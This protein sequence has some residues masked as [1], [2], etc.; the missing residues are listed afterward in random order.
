[1][2]IIN[3]LN[4]PGLA[5][6][7]AI[8]GYTI[9]EIASLQVIDSVLYELEHDATGAKHVHI[10]NNDAENTFSVA[11]KTVPHDSTGV[12]HILEHTALCGS[13]LFPVRDPF[14]SMLKRSLSTFMNAFTASD[15][16]MYPFTTQNHKD[17]YNLADVYLDSAFYPNIDELSFKQEGY[18][19]EIE[20]MTAEPDHSRLV[21]KGV[22]YNEMKGAMSSPDQVMA[23][24]M[25]NALYPDV[26]YCHNSGGEP[27]VIPSL[28]HAELV[29]FHRRHYHPSN[30]FFYTYGNL[31]LKEHL[32]FI[33]TKI[34]SHFDLIDPQTDVPPQPRWLKPRTAFYPYPLGPNEN[35]EKKYQVCIAWL[36]AD[37][38]DSFEVLVL[39]LLEQILL[40]NS[41]SP[42][43]RALIE[44]G[45]G[46]ALSDGSGFDPDN[47][48]TLFACGLKDVK[49]TDAPA[50]E[51]IIFDVFN[52]LIDN[53]IEAER[54]ESAI[55]QIE[56]HRK[57]VTNTPYPYGIKLLLTFAGSWFHGGAPLANLNIDANLQKL[58]EA[59]AQGSFLENR[60]KQYFLENPH[61]MLFTLTPDQTLAAKETQRVEKELTA[62]KRKL[63]QADLAKIASDADALK[64]LQET[65]EDLSCLPTLALDEIPPS[66]QTVLAHNAYSDTSA[67]CYAQ[68]TAGIVY[69]TAAAGAGAIP[70]ESVPLTS[71]FC[72]A[73]PRMGTAKRDYAQMAQRIS[74]Y[75]GGLGLAPIVRTCFNPGEGCLPFTTFSG[76]CLERN[77]DK[78]FAIIEE[79][80]CEYAFTD[81][82]RLKSILFEYRAG[83]EAMVVQN[84]HHLAMALACRHFSPTLALS[85][86]WQG[87]HQLKKIKAL[88]DLIANPELSQNRLEQ[89][90]ANLTQIGQILFKQENLKMGLVGEEHVLYDAVPTI[91][92]MR[93]QIPTGAKNGFIP[94]N[95][96]EYENKSRREGWTTAT[97][98]AFV[99]NAFKT[100]RLN[101]E[102]APALSVISKLL[103]SLYLHREIREKGG[104]YG[105]FALYNSSEGIF[106]LASY[107]DP[108][109][110]NTL[111]VFT[112]ATAFICSGRYTDE[113]I[114]EAILQ[115]CSI[116][117]KPDTPGTA[118]R[119]AFYRNLI[120][121]SDETREE[122]KTGLLALTRK[123]VVRV[124]E[125]YFDQ[126]VNAP[127]VAVIAGEEQLENANAKLGE[128]AL[129]LEEI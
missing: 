28:K 30:A 107:R 117:D 45:I 75:T 47:R 112:K 3:D 116:I 102:D 6:G 15:W 118:A 57:E 26:T 37:I 46:S 8:H 77:Q 95:L 53:G 16:T 39:T 84:G 127:C 104:A 113:D 24:S 25:M 12:A 51:K 121:L 40:G 94:P 32:R 67:L 49:K 22:V 36:T 120:S 21:Y 20:P 128:Q 59:L 123:D 69:F 124:A 85:E 29:A 23:R 126:Q 86:I 125:K 68:P 9:K 83:L 56:F 48:D 88:T 115:V 80:L 119:K 14:F 90:A 65:G 105:G 17:F 7:D 19:L 101:H 31:P 38:K 87:V 91:A 103:R 78:M 63:T 111:K 66:I 42:L 4:N 74:L 109:I 122:Y 72:S 93:N 81:L 18:R 44:S 35:P 89:T 10:S 58:R 97:A 54:I 41:S 106:S 55:H 62:L 11:F 64:K 5:K 2:N 96:S 129:T 114:K 34:L 27:A 108:H 71:L 61:R 100:V 110:V 73:L 1:M 79:L 50:I 99:A 60:I 33:N 52:H 92:T 76:K 82:D 43:R 98:V 13:R 70:Q